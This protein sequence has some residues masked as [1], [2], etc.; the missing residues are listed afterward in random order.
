MIEEFNDRLRR[1]CRISEAYRPLLRSGSEISWTEQE[2]ILDLLG[3]RCFCIPYETTVII[4]SMYI[5]S[6]HQQVIMWI[7]IN[8]YKVHIVYI[9]ALQYLFSNNIINV[10]PMKIPASNFVD[11]YKLLWS[12]NCK[13]TDSGIVDTILKK[14]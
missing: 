7:F 1:S 5:L 9:K 10:C 8:Y 11:I 3:S 12:S 13:S 4:E 14:D 2:L 6:K